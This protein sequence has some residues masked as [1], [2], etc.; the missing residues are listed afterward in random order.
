M[1]N[2]IFIPIPNIDFL[3]PG[4]I[5]CNSSEDNQLIL[6]PDE[7]EFIKFVN[8]S[9]FVTCIGNNTRWVTPEGDDITDTKGR[10]HIEPRNEGTLVLMFE[11][12]H[13][14]DHGQWFCVSDADKSEKSFMMRVYE[15]ID[16]VGVRTIQSARESRDTVIECKVKGI[17]KP[18]VS[19]D[20]NGQPIDVMC[21][22]LNDTIP[23]EKIINFPKNIRIPV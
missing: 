17:P 10:V 1:F 16:F 15:P 14:K 3:I 12:I 7:P 4:S 11:K 21:E 23:Y 6:M 13:Y 2:F 19:W 9:L 18:E 22:C 8:D 20:F 5:R